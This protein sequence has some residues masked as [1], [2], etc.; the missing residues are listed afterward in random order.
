MLIVIKDNSSGLFNF[1]ELNTLTPGPITGAEDTQMHKSVSF[2][3]C[4]HSR[5]N[6][7]VPSVYLTSPSDPLNYTS[8][9]L[10]GRRKWWVGEGASMIKGTPYRAACRRSC[11]VQSLILSHVHVYCLVIGVWE[12]HTSQGKFVEVRG[13]LFGCVCVWGGFSFHRVSS[14]D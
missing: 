12:G 10:W 2:G 4:L 3:I 6:S 14:R 8:P 5:K 7:N 11:R 1:P 13:W 9:R